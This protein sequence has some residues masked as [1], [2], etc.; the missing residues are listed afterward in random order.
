MIIKIKKWL[1]KY[2]NVNMAIRILVTPLFKIEEYISLLQIQKRKNSKKIDENYRKLRELKDTHHGEKCFIVATGPSLRMEDLQLIKNEFSFGM[3]SSILAFDK[4]EWRPS[5]YGIQDEYVY[6]ALRTEIEKQSKL[7]LKN[8]IIVGDNIKKKFD[9]P[10]DWR[11]F[12]LHYLDHKMYHKNGYGTFEFFEDCYAAVNDGYSITLS[13]LQIACYMGFSEIYLL[14]CDC[15]YNLPKAHFIENG[16]ND[17]HASIMGDKMIQAHFEFNKFAE[18]NGVSVVNCTRG[19]MLEV[20][21]RA[22]L[23]SVLEKI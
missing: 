2:D 20:Y 21:P 11:V 5:L 15:N 23:E 4:T 3:N 8:R 7:D 16:Y 22:T 1:K 6:E 19:G 12:H 9:V 10:A 13:L 14:G 17:P 18:A